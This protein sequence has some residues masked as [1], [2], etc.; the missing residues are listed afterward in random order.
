MLATKSGCE[1]V[2]HALQ[3]LTELNPRTTVASIDGTSERFDIAS[4]HVGRDEAHCSGI[5]I[6]VRVH[7][8]WHSS[9]CLG[10]RSWQGFTP[11]RRAKVENRATQSCLCCSHWA[12]TPLQRVQSQLREGEHLLAFLDDI[13]AVTTPERACEVHGIVK[14]LWSQGSSRHDP[15]V[16]PGRSGTSRLPQVTGGGCVVGPQGCRGEARRSCQCSEE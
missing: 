7:V 3:G 13:Y 15:S 4:G 12:N 11:F 6:A 10:R 5:S 8:L 1:S 2:A 9:S 14:A 16:E